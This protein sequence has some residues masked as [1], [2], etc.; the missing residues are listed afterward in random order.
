MLHFWG[1]RAGNPEGERALDRAV[2]ILRVEAAKNQR[3]SVHARARV[4]A[5]VGDPQRARMD[6]EPLAT[7]FLPARRLA[8]ASVLPMLLLS[9]MLGY[10]MIPAERGGTLTVT[11]RGDQVIFSI[12]NGHQSHR[13]YRS[14]NPTR[15]DTVY[16]TTARAFTDQLQSGP[17]LVFYRVD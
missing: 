4:L 14:D 13:V 12:S 7:L 10:L 5:A 3:L 15:F 1:P 11:K 8:L 2:E 16:T 9:L 17:D 6:R